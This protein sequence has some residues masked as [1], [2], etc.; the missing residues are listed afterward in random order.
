MDEFYQIQ[1]QKVAPEYAADPEVKDAL[2]KSSFVTES[3]RLKHTDFADLY[4]GYGGTTYY[5]DW[6]VPSTSDLYFKS[7]CHAVELAYVFN[8]LEDTIYCG[9]N[10]DEA[11]AERAHTAWANFAKSG[12]P[13]IKGTEWTTYH[14]DSRNTMMI[15]LRDWKME[16]DPNSHLREIMTEIMR[17]IRD[18]EK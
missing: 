3:T 13:S 4:S 15:R 17:E 11:T 9:P 6:T 14:A 5:Y 7:A 12:N 8:N 2:I 1:G 10:P 18:N 16:S